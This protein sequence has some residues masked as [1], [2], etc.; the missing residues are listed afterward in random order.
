MIVTYIEHSSFLLETDAAYLLFDYYAGSVK[1]PSLR[2]DKPL[3]IFSSHVHG[4]HYS[5]KIFELAK[6]YP[7]LHF[8][9]DSGISAPSELKDLCTVLEPHKTHAI[10]EID[11]QLFTLASNDLGV[12]FSITLKEHGKDYAVYHAGDL[13]NWWW[14]GDEED[15]QSE[16]FYHREL[17]LIRGT[18]Y[19][20]A[21]IPLDPRIKGW[22]KGIDDFM[23]DADADYIFP[24]HNFG[25]YSMPQKLL[26]LECSSLY[27]NKIMDVKKP[28]Q[29]WTIA[30]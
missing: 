20:A 2:S 21:F 27:R 28:L 7:N 10:P 26:H 13:N 5:P 15:Q 11:G 19:L 30:I 8:F 14:D 23:H 29:S 12:A 3:F 9:L 17:S 6:Q 25:D 18:H 22:W 24:M 1:L 4:D 16:K